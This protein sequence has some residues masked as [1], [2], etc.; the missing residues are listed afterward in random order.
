LYRYHPKLLSFPTRRSSDLQ[1]LFTEQRFSLPEI[2]IGN[3][4]LRNI[5][6]TF[7][8]RQ[9]SLLALAEQVAG[10]APRLYQRQLFELDA[11]LDEVADRKSTRL[12]SSHVQI[13]Y[14]G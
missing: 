8:P 5:R 10:L 2:L 4:R 7:R 1:F 14:A 13:S 11:F 12:N 9:C 3:T 6:D